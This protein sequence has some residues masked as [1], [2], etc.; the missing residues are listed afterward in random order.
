MRTRTIGSLTVSEVGM[1]CMGFSH[2]YGPIP[3]EEESIEAIRT[4]LDAGCTF[5]DTA[6]GYGPN[7]L[8]ENR[9]HNE[10][11]L[12]KALEGRREDVVLATK[13]HV[14][15]VEAAAGGV[16]ATVRRH[17]EGSLERL[18]TD[19]VELYYLHR[20]NPAVP[21][22]EV[23]SAMGLLID[24]GLIGGW[25][26]SQV[27][28][29]TIRAAH[30]VTPLTAVQNIYS[31]VERGVEEEVLPWTE[32]H[33]VGLV[34]F[35]PVSSGLLSG[36]V[37]TRTQFAQEDGVRRFVPQ[38]SP[39]NLAANEPLVELLRRT[40]E[41]KGATPAQI[42]MAW[43]LGRWEHVVPIPGSKNKGRI[44]ENLGASDVRLSAEELA[45]LQAAL[46]AI[47]VHGHRGFDEA[48]G[49]SFLN[50]PASR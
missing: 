48:E 12:A 37:T 10:R 32:A 3:S 5:L 34:A 29:D 36:R 20:V 1:G 49:R 8:P 15:T 30:E 28:L 50:R 24:E 47:E 39:E 44:L 46:D 22:T 4:G 26:L 41:A 38:L 25:G 27:T 11:I 45:E 43:M 40:A 35:S 13:L 14:P 7:L 18:G 6:E 31:M 33:G 16:A 17:L 23:A 2:G 21:V 19:H 9:G 42:S